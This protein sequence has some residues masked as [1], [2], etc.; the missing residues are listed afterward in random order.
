MALIGNNAFSDNRYWVAT[1]TSNWNNTANWSTTSG[2]AG[3]SSVPLKTDTAKFDGNGLGNCNIDMAVRIGGFTID[4]VFTA[5]IDLLG[6]GFITS[7]TV[8]LHT[9][10]I[11]DSPGTGVFT[12][13]SSEITIFINVIF[14][15]VVNVSSNNI[16]VAG[17]FFNNT[18]SFNKTG[19]FDN[20]SFGHNIFNGTTSFINLGTGK[21][22][23][24][25]FAPDTFNGDVTFNAI[26]NGIYPA[27]YGAN[28]FNGN[29]VIKGINTVSFCCGPAT[30]TLNRGK[31]ISAN[32]F[33]GNLYIKKFTQL[34]ST[35]QRL[36][37]SGGLYIL[38][39]CKFNGLLTTNT[40]TV[41]L[42]KSQ[43][44]GIRML[45]KRDK[46]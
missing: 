13:K 31:T 5:N 28:Q 24:A 41:K 19:G 44:K 20:Y 35:P 17:S 6:Y 9:G 14:E 23:L 43:F 32:G 33:T 18:A 36:D 7:G 45:H 26:T 22:V 29:I 39:N 42:S 2:G 15:A 4:S 25:Y 16:Y 34:G 10:I 1:V 40:L 38:N 37:F 3:G 12:I 27:R 8:T 46:M 30:A 21:F 11:N